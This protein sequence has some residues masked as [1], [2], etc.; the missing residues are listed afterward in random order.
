VLDKK[1]AFRIEFSAYEFF[2]RSVAM[3]Q[4][5]SDKILDETGHIGLLTVTIENMGTMR[6][7]AI[8][9]P[10]R[11]LASQVACFKGRETISSGVGKNPWLLVSYSKDDGILVV[12]KKAV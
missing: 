8:G 4:E 1:V 5:E 9:E 11:M 12:K 6:I 2:S 3:T 10:L 7:D